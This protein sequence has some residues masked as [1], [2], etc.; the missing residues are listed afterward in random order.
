MTHRHRNSH[1]ESAD[2]DNPGY[3]SSL[4]LLR[5]RVADATTYPFNLAVV[6]ALENR[7]ELHPGATFFVG[8]NGTGKSTVIEAIAVA[9][10]FNPEGGTKNFQFSTRASES[11]LHQ[12][13]R[14]SR[15][16]KRPSTGFFFRA[17]SFFN[18]ATNIENLD[19]VPAFSP[20]VIESYGGRSL[21]EQ[22]HGESFMALVRHRFG[23]NGLYIL[24]EPEAS[25]SVR[26]QI[27]LLREL[28]A[29]VEKKGSQLIVATHSPILLALPNA[30]IY[31]FAPD[32]VSRI[33][34]EETDAFQLS[35]DFMMDPASAL[36]DID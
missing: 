23:A 29:H 5:D 24:D 12:C 30:L 20:P 17:E 27:E 2:L 8:D 7:L 31:R 22:S 26:W 11:S 4:Q 1:S 33:A 10:G 35:H 19:S 16:Y 13:I 28:H 32:G 9:A 18:V 14:I 15:T 21:H 34:Y 25:L 36:A 6:R 3:I